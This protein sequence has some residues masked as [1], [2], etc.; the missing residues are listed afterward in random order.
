MKPSNSQRNSA[1]KPL[2]NFFGIF[3]KGSFLKIFLH[4]DK[5]IEGSHVTMDGCLTAVQVKNRKISKILF[6]KFG[7]KMH[8][9]HRKKWFGDGL[10][11]FG[12]IFRCF[13]SSAGGGLEVGKELW[14][15]VEW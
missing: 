2:W 14:E 4:F 7:S 10:S 12:N 6:K 15:V 5:A 3:F 9:N 11:S 1:L 8:Q 13:W